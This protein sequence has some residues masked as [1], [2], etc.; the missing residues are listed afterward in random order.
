[1]NVSDTDLDVIISALRDTA[2]V[3]RREMSNTIGLE[4]RNHLGAYVQ[5]AAALSDR[6]EAERPR[7]PK[8]I[9][10]GH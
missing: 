1:M 2:M 9:F 3:K 7:R 10:K 4:H 5:Y 8:L 6:L